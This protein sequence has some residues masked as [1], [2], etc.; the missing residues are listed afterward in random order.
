MKLNLEIPNR[1]LALVAG[2]GLCFAAGSVIAT[3][4]PSDGEALAYSGVLTDS[5]GDPRQTTDTIQ[6][7]LFAAQSGGN[8]LCAGSVAAVDLGASQ[9]RFRVPL[10]ALCSDVISDNGDVWAEVTVAST[11]LPRQRLGATAF[12]VS[13]RDAQRAD[14]ADFAET[15]ADGSITDTKLAPALAASFASAAAVASLDARLDAIDG[16]LAG[17]VLSL[18]S[19]P[20]ASWTGQVTGVVATPTQF[21]STSELVDRAGELT[22]D[23]FF[24]SRPGLYLISGMWNSSNVG[25]QCVS[26]VIVYKNQGQLGPTSIGRQSIGG[27]LID[28]LG[29]TVSIV[30]PLTTGDRIRFFG[31]GNCGGNLVGEFQVA[32]LH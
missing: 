6:V 14:L 5:A 22:A 12:A 20:F 10:P 3:E 2:G 7:K 30:A 27:G 16:V 4:F 29:G 1:I 17:G 31:S 28:N 8:A 23:G 25:D 26:Y 9:G 13:A 19:Q 24:A 18:P 15:V 21:P 11:T 32:L